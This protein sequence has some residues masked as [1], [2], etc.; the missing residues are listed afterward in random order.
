[1]LTQESTD[2]AIELLPTCLSRQQPQHRNKQITP[3]PQ[4]TKFCQPLLVVSQVGNAKG[5][6]ERPGKDRKKS[7]CDKMG[8][9]QVSKCP[10]WFSSA[11]TSCSFTL[12]PL[13]VVDGRLCNDENVLAMHPGLHLIGQVCTEWVLMHGICKLNS[14]SH[15]LRFRCSCCKDNY[16]VCCLVSGARRWGQRKE[17]E[18]AE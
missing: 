16:K 1:M 2:C 5:Y 4:N 10:R 18:D 13:R 9:E 6:L 7:V 14:I 17:C 12:I 15:S 3:S 11:S 8:W